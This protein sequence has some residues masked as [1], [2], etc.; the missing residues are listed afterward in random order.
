MSH[1]F[2]WRSAVVHDAYWLYRLLWNIFYIFSM[3]SCFMYWLFMRNNKQI[4]IDGFNSRPC[5]EPTKRAIFVLRRTKYSTLLVVSVTVSESNPMRCLTF[6]A[7]YSDVAVNSMNDSCASRQR[8]VH[9]S[10]GRQAIATNSPS[11]HMQYAW[12]AQWR[13][14]HI[15]THEDSYTFGIQ[16]IHHNYYNTIL[17]CVCS[18]TIKCY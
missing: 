14:P 11:K 6:H 12:C 10:T 15:G 2:K 1:D 8:S 17:N 13:S 3:F 9:R 7:A 5:M 4:I 16:Q 18:R